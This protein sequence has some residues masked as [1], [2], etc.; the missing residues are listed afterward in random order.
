MTFNRNEVFILP[1]AD[2]T[3]LLRYQLDIPYANDSVFQKLDL[4]LPNKGDGPFPVI[5]F[6][7]GG[8]WRRGDKSD[9]QVEAFFKLLK[10]GYAVASINWRLS[11]EA[12]YPKAVFD[13]KAAIR[14][15]R[16]HAKELHLDP[17]RV[18]AAGDSAGGY[19]ALMLA[20]TAGR[21]E[22]EDLSMGC[23]DERSDVSCAVAWYPITDFL[24]E[25][26]Q[27]KE[28]EIE[29]IINTSDNSREYQDPHS[30][31]GAFLGAAL[32]QF[33]PFY[34]RQVSP[35]HYIS[36]EMAPVLLQHGREDFIAPRQQS[37]SFYHR[38]VDVSGRQSA[39]LDILDGAVHIDPVFTTDENM[40]RV[41]RF[42]DTHLAAVKDI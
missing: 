3:G 5:A 16:A 7:H 11:F 29:G 19:L 4:Y 33:H 6:Y 17:T 12:K 2:K 22:L 26:A 36:K 21:A 14:Y 15:L 40:T 18:A 20:T 23:P 38:A 25:F 30:P 1:E 42:L 24:T 9:M 41:A 39:E 34:L 31:E 13:A 8:G 37:E 27:S 32:S 10:F 35:I 28:N